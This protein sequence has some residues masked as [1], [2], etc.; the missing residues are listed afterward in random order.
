MPSLTQKLSGE[1]V[2]LQYGANAVGGVISFKSEPVAA[3]GTMR[4][5]VQSEY[6]TSNGLIGNSLDIGGNKN[7]LAWDIKGKF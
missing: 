5:S 1:L 4:G 3:P 6:Q 2:S 7:G